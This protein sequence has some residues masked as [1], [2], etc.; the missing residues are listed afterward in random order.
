[1]MKMKIKPYKLLLFIL[2]IALFLAGCARNIT[3]KR[4]ERPTG[5]KVKV[6]EKKGSVQ[7]KDKQGKGSAEFGDNVKM[8]EAFPKDIPIYSSAKIKSAISSKSGKSTVVMVTFET[9]D[10][11]AKVGDYYKGAL[12]A[13]GYGITAT[14]AAGNLI[15]L[16]AEK[17]QTKVTISVNG[18][19]NRT[20]VLISVSIEAGP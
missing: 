20:A 18:G 16:S 2:L 14:Q 5:G 17:K 19:N 11:I 7:F 3:D 8:P 4:V 6:D 9:R 15:T 13:N 10:G 12:T 1:M